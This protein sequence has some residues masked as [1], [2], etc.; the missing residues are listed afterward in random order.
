[1]RWALINVF[2]RMPESE[3]F[4]DLV[5]VVSKHFFM[6][7]RFNE[8]R[9]V[10]FLSLAPLIC[11]SIFH[12]LVSPSGEIYPLAVLVLCSGAF[13]HFCLTSNRDFPF[14]FFIL[15]YH[16]LTTRLNY[17]TD[18]AHG[19]HVHGY[20]QYDKTGRRLREVPA[21]FI[22]EYHSVVLYF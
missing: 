5:S 6:F 22:V 15:A 1:M 4:L 17:P 18:S 14:L 2:P 7:G 20:I 12:L 13:L 10:R 16:S 9:P 8:A 21:Y 3:L 11:N 19:T